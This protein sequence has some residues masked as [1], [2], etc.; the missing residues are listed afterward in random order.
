MRERLFDIW[1]HRNT[2]ENM[3]LLLIG[4]LVLSK[5][6]GKCDHRGLQA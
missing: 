2:S 1:M 4:G 6:T 3:E 5:G